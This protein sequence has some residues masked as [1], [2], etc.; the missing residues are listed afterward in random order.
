MGRTSKG[1]G[2]K[3]PPRKRKFVRNLRT[4]AEQKPPKT[5]TQQPRDPLTRTIACGIDSVFIGSI[6]PMRWLAGKTHELAHR[7]WGERSMGRAIDLLHAAFTD[8]LEEPSLLLDY[9]FVMN[10]FQP[11]Y[12][13]L[14]EFEEFLEFYR[15]DKVGNVH[16]S[17]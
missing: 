8:I 17:S 2:F 1:S 11:L 10:I 14:P 5:T 6:V 13:D 16:G 4:G 9:E 15:E 3:G 12:N 7:G